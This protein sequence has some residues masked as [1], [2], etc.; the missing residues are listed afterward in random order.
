MSV[1]MLLA[2]LVFLPAVFYYGI[3]GLLAVAFAVAALHCWV[4]VVRWQPP[5]RWGTGKTVMSRYACFLIGCWL[6][7]ISAHIIFQGILK[8]P[9]SVYYFAGH[10]AFALW[11]TLLRK[12]VA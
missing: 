10:V 9:G 5:L 1:L 11:V 8:R 7:Y 3:L 6:A 2:G 12:N 4:T